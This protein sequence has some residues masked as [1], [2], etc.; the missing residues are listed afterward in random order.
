M[1][2]EE[3]VTNFGIDLNRDLSSYYLSGTQVKHLVVGERSTKGEFS[4]IALIPDDQILGN[5][6]YLRRIVTIISIGAVMLVPL[7]LLLLGNVVLRPLKRIMAA[8]RRIGDGNLNLRIEPFP[9][10]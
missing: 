2:H 1:T 7:C 4:L 8:M 10:F 5:L 6:P 9:A 3:T